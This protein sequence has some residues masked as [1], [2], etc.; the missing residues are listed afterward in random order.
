[1]MLYSVVAGGDRCD[2]GRGVCNPLWWKGA[3]AEMNPESFW[4]V[5]SFLLYDSSG[6]IGDSD[7]LASDIDT[8]HARMPLYNAFFFLSR[9]WFITIIL[10]FLVA[11]SLLCGGFCLDLVKGSRS[12]T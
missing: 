9:G 1:M 10:Q 12:I 5:C 7:R 8:W 2:D 3:A 6:I 4:F 11:V